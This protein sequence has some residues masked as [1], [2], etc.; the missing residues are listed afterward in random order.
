[1][2]E[3]SIRTAMPSYNKLIALREICYGKCGLC[4]IGAVSVEAISIT[5]FFILVFAMLYAS[6]CHCEKKM[7]IF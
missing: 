7:H 1:M 5:T 6:F 2:N 4:D 3:V